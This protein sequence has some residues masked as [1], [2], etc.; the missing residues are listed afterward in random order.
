MNC[1]KFF[2]HLPCTFEPLTPMEKRFDEYEKYF[3]NQKSMICQTL[4]EKHK[5]PIQSTSII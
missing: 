4:K 1:D 2:T 5:A 3:N